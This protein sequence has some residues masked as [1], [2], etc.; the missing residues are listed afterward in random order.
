MNIIND[1]RLFEKY[2]KDGSE[3]FKRTN[4]DITEI[5]VH[6]SGGHDTATGIIGWML[7][8][9]LM[10]DGTTREKDYRKGISLF[11]TEIDRNGDVYNILSP[12]YWCY[13]SS[14]GQHDKC[15]IGIELVSIKPD[16]KAIYSDEQ[17]SSLYE[18]IDAYLGVFPIKT[19]VGHGF[20]KKKYKG[21]YKNCPGTYF[22]WNKLAK[23]FNLKQI[24]GE[25]FKIA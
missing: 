25:C 14:S 11:H 24:A 9:G 2:F 13:H 16:N 7:N 8:G 10:A 6:G 5:V 21:G 15:S 18:M 1:D 22:D 12:L 3:K 4:E 17:Y 19:I 20:N 23:H